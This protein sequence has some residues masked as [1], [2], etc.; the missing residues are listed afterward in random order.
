MEPEVELRVYFPVEMEDGNEELLV[1]IVCSTIVPLP[2]EG[3]GHFTGVTCGY[4]LWG[5]NFS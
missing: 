5:D 1:L 3:K 2:T 4:G